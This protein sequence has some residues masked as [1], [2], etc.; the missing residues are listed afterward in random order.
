MMKK[1]RILILL[2]FS[3]LLTSCQYKQEIRYSYLYR[4]DNYISEINNYEIISSEYLLNK[5]KYDESFINAEVLDKYNSYFF[6]FNS[7]IYFEVSYNSGL[8]NSVIVSYS[9]NENTLNINLRRFL[10][11]YDYDVV[12]KD[13]YVLE[14]NKYVAN[15]IDNIE[16]NIN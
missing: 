12:T 6:V 7:L 4:N 5:Y 9:L 10:K 3:F 15:K 1:L 8:G 14:I 11:L 13:I 2:I 16:V